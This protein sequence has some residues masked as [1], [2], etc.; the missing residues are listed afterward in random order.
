MNPVFVA[1]LDFKKAVRQKEFF[2]G[3]DIYRGLFVEYQCHQI[4]QCS[5][6]RNLCADWR[7]A[8]SRGLDGR[9]LAC[10]GNGC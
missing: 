8:T 9:D 6:R 5:S 10:A 2:Q 4:H 1:E 7:S 3:G